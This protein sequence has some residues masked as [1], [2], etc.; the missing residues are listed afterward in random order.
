M[1]AV[2][3]ARVSD[4]ER[5]DHRS[6][7]EQELECREAATGHG[8]TVDKVFT[9]NSRSASRYATKVREEYERLLAYLAEAPVDVLILWESSRGGRELE[10]WA[11]MLNLCRRRGVLIHVVTHERTY[12]LKKSR[13][14][15]VLAEDGVNNAYASDETSERV[16]RT[17]RTQAAKGKPHGKLLYGYK[18][19]YD[20]R[21][22]FVAQVEHPEQAAVVREAARRIKAGDSLYAIAADFNARA[23]PAPRGGQWIPTQIKRICVNPA[24]AGLRVHQGAVVG[25]AV[26]AA[27]LDEETF[28]ACVRRLTDPARKTLRDTSLKHMLSGAL[29]GACGGRMRVLKS[30]G[31]LTYSCTVDFCTAVR[32]D[33]VEKAVSLFVTERLENPDI[34]EAIASR[35]DIAAAGAKSR[36][37]ELRLRLDG[38]YEAAALGHITPGALAK[39]EARLAPEIEAAE[40]QAVYAPVPQLLRDVAGPGARE[41]WETL[42]V[43]QKRELVNLVA[44]LRLS[45]TVRGSRFTHWRLAESRWVGDDRTWGDVWVAADLE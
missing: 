29:K 21:G 35:G 18:R 40:A 37:R 14:W 15:K 7:G 31:Y 8:W 36:V 44:D 33:R 27:L 4:D 43:G 6:V 41:R 20:A 3:Y 12:D 10:R 9:D 2:I 24:Y 34:L 1:R 22:V 28:S 32:T 17:V 45:R 25:P 42:T 30:R 23:I 26:W 16:L 39:I 19:E 11:G 5:Q 38:F 13:D